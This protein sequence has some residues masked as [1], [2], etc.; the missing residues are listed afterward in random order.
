MAVSLNLRRR[1]YRPHG[2]RAEPLIL[3]RRAAW[4]AEHGNK[5]VNYLTGVCSDFGSGNVR[6]NCQS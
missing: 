3:K 6:S 4:A 2:F 5:R 1:N